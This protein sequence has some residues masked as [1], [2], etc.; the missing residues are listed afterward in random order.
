MHEGKTGTREDKEEEF[1]EKKKGRVTRVIQDEMHKEEMGADKG[2]TVSRLA[3][4]GSPRPPSTRMCRQLLMWRW[5]GYVINLK[6]SW[7]GVRRM[8]HDE[9]RRR[10]PG[11]RSLHTRV[12][13]FF[14][15]GTNRMEIKINPCCC[16]P[17]L[18]D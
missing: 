11:P 16:R 13:P 18:Y 7:R 6:E 5:R 17:M 10:Q 2:E 15:E 1:I 9:G 12:G 14:Y 3:K 8:T 4:R